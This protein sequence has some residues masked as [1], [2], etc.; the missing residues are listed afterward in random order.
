[1]SA[2]KVCAIVVTFNGIEWIEKCLNSV[3]GSSIKIDLIV[4]DNGSTD[5]TI[6]YLDNYDKLEFLVKSDVNLGFGKA[7]NLGLKEGYG[8]GYEYFLLLNQ[9]A[10]VDENVVEVLV[11]ALQTQ[12]DYGIASPMHYDGTGKNLDFLFSSY[13]SRTSSYQVDLESNSLKEK[14]YESP[15]INAAC[16]LMRRNTLQQVGL[17]NPLFDHYG[18]DDNY[19]HRLN[20]HGLKLGLHPFVKVYHDRKSGP[21]I[22]KDDPFR[23]FRRHILW[24]M[25]RSENSITLFTALRN[26]VKHSNKQ[27]K[28]LSSGS[29]VLFVLKCYIECFRLW[30]QV[31]DFK[32]NREAELYLV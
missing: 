29:K 23:L 1:M 16:W 28:H 9:D 13:L 11:N 2:S 24:E 19:I 26:A 20:N 22:L 10:W 17:F 14:L 5:G 25:L 3:A 30:Y 27:S 4:V 15:F 7:N 18:E 12:V 21:N 32:R 31:N 6:E 8:R